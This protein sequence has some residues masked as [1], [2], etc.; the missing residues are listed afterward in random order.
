M[1]LQQI[2]YIVEIAKYGS[3]CKASQELCVVQPHLSSTLKNLEKE[4]GITIFSRTRKGVEL[5]SDG[6]EFLI[7]AK[8]LLNQEEKILEL[9]SNNM[10]KPIFRFSISTQHYPFIV[11]SFYEFFEDLTPEHYEI[12]LRETNMYNVI[13]DVFNKRSNLGIIFLSESTE[14]FITKYL[15]VRNIQFDLIKQVTP[16]VFFRRAH[17]MAK[18]EFVTLEEMI[19]YPFASFDFE[20][21]IPPEFSEEMFFYNSPT[22]NKKFFVSDRGTMINTLTHTDAFSI[23]T[24]ILPSEFVGYELIS[25]PIKDYGSEIK[26]I[27]IKSIDYKLTEFDIEFIHKV[28]DVINR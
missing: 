23:G 8:S 16:C 26:L 12:H 3:I 10:V 21:S 25:K 13:N 18:N 19:Q 14:R 5:T 27:W 4:L 17:P 2:K 24:G 22:V 7:Y 15:A 1:T 9:Y 6:K 11:E 20:T 28:K